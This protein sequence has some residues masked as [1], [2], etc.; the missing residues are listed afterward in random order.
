M[1]LYCCDATNSINKNMISSFQHNQATRLITG[2][3][4]MWVSYLKDNKVTDHK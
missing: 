1:I 3:R 2:N 4:V